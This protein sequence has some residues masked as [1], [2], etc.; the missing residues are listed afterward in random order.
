MPAGTR[1]RS[2]C[3]GAKNSVSYGMQG[4]G[5]TTDMSPLRTLISC[6]SSS[7]LVSAEPL[8]ELR[9]LA[10]AVELV[11]TAVPDLGARRHRR[12]DVLPVHRVVDIDGHC[13]ELERGELLHVQPEPRL[14]E[15]HGPR[16]VPLDPEGDVGEEGRRQDQP[17]RRG[18][19]VDAA[20][21]EARGRRQLDGRQADKRQRLDRVHLHPRA[22]RL[23][24]PGDEVD[25]DRARLEAVND[26]EQVLVPVVR[27]GDDHAVDTELVDERRQVVDAAEQTEVAD[28]AAPHPGLGV[29][30]ADEL[31][32][33][34]RVL[35]DL[36]GDQLADVAGTDHDRVLY[37]ERAP[38]RDRPADGTGSD[39]ER[40]RHD[41][42]GDHARRVLRGGVREPDH[43]R[44]DPHPDRDDGEDAEEVIHRGMVRA[45]VVA[46]V[47]SAEDRDRHPN[48]KAE[49]ED[50]ALQPRRDDVV[51]APARL[52]QKLTEDEGEAEPE[53]VGDEQHA[54]QEPVP[55]SAHLPFDRACRCRQRERVRERERDS[56]PPRCTGFTMFATPRSTP[57]SGG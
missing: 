6:G 46:A 16:R 40:D 44:E 21:D 12:L 57:R 37:E 52:E 43:T 32:S 27:V 35:L 38:A 53:D 31:D 20:L 23:E 30:E 28:V 1:K 41:P 17:D 26:L 18:D 15:E 8:S 9:H 24:Q 4:R 50:S 45:R 2:K 14:A 49:D 39:D 19:Q 22:D 56:R 10:V 48:G 7:R 33:V 13:P 3:C 29:Y 51:C 54:V 25:V 34:L 55:P 47:Q 5:P 36:A 42:E 11:E